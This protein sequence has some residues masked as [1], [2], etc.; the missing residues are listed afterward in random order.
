M[1]IDIFVYIYT[2][3]FHT[4]PFCDRPGVIWAARPAKEFNNVAYLLKVPGLSL[5][6]C[7]VVTCFIRYVV[8]SSRHEIYRTP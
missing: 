8:Q 2:H 5:S 3:V 7:L 1:C 6:F 4:S